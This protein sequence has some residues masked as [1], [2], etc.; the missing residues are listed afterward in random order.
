LKADTLEGFSIGAEKLK[1]IENGNT[2]VDKTYDSMEDIKN[3][4]ALKEYNVMVG[5]SHFGEERGR[6]MI[7][8]DGDGNVTEFDGK[9]FRSWAG[10]GDAADFRI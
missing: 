4:P 5:A 10:S 3:D 6:K 8:K 1:V 9:S 2:V 7:F